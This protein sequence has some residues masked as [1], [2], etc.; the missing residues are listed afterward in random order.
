MNN[1]LI[2][3]PSVVTCFCDSHL[4]STCFHSWSFAYV[5]RNM[6]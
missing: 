5:Q 6:R 1:A 2:A 4:P 3:N